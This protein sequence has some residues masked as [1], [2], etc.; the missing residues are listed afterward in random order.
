[1][2]RGLHPGARP[3][4]GFRVE[5][6]EGGALYLTMDD[7]G[8]RV[9]VLDEAALADLNVALVELERLKP[10]G[11]ILRS[12][13]AGSFIAGADIQAISA[14][15]DRARVLELVRL[16]HGA[17]GRLAA[18][19]CPTV[20][21]IDGVCLGGGTELALACASRL[22]TEEPRTQIGLPEVLLGIFPGF[23]GTPG[24]RRLWGLPPRSDRTLP[25]ARSTPGVRG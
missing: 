23:G 3:M 24:C 5:P 19:A 17:F 2:G 4:R 20:A 22:A 21:A 25:G 1:P 15:T 8:R 6:A 7:P 11:V 13:K 9:N 14:I 18:L 16:A 12:G 10:T